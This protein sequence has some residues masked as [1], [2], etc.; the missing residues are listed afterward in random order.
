MIS[1]YANGN[2]PVPK[3]PGVSLIANEFAH[4]DSERLVGADPMTT[5]SQFLGGIGAKAVQ[6]ILAGGVLDDV[7]KHVIDRVSAHSL[8]TYD[9][10]LKK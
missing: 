4:V 10:L 7:W 6:G 5:L 3:L 1:R 9:S 8:V 2:D